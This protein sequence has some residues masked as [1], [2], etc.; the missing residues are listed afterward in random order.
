MFLIGS[1]C[2]LCI[3]H[4]RPVLFSG[5]YSNIYNRPKV[6]EEPKKVRGRPLF[7]F[8]QAGE[9]LT[10]GGASLIRKKM[11]ILIVEAERLSPPPQ[12]QPLLGVCGPVCIKVMVLCHMTICEFF[13]YTLPVGWSCMEEAINSSH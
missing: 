6:I 10:G 12:Q 3:Q 8:F 9:T 13:S 4:M 2:R 1:V 11:F 7:L 5:T